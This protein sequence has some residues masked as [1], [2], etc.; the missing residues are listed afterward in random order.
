MHPSTTQA[1]DPAT[2]PRTAARQLVDTLVAHGV[3]RVFCVAGESFLAV[4][5]ALYDSPIDVVTCRHEASAGFAALA[6]AKLTG[7]PGVILV[8]RG[9]GASNATIAVHSAIQDAAPLLLVV[10]Q[11]ERNELGR[12][13]FQEVDYHLTYADLAKGVWTLHDAE[14]TSE[15][16]ARALRTAVQ[17][18]PGPTVLVL[19]E[20]VLN[21]TLPSGPQ[22]RSV[23]VEPAPPAPAAMAEI[24]RL[25][26]AAERPLVIAG[27]LLR[28]EES[29]RRLRDAAQRHLLPVAV[30]NKH[31]D[32]FDNTHPLYAGHLH[33]ATQA[34]QRAMLAQADLVIAVGTR[35]D[36]VTTQNHTLP[37]APVPTQPLV[38]VHPDPSALGRVTEPTI[39][40]ACDPVAF[41]TALADTTTVERHGEQR[42]AWAGLLHQAELA[43]A[44]WQPHESI[45]GLPFGAAV[46]ALGR[47]AAPDTIVTVDAGNFTS[48]VHRY[49]RFTDRGTLLGLGCGAMG[50]GVPSGLAAALR[51]PDRQVVTFVGDGGFLMT[52]TELATA[53]QRRARLAIIVAD[54]GSYGT[55]RQHQERAYPARVVATDLLNPD[56]AALALSFGARGL[57]VEEERDLVPALEEALGYDGPIVV[58]VRTSLSWISAYQHLAM[59]GETGT[60][61]HVLSAAGALVNG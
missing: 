2:G 38:H 15:M 24:A 51:H 31:Q 49:H 40:L 8:N 19:P 16:T 52:G 37:A 4:L 10:G 42:L 11:V 45:D 60:H 23:P 14:R 36:S 17:G 20:D 41:L 9:P 21:E 59:P 12:G 1:A 47:L 18:T 6:D 28:T 5:D 25:L 46:E 27:G 55:I 61:P 13:C 43:T 30:S 39:A 26:A 29:R 35:L 32:V 44:T 56:F 53:V 48:W 34:A 58:A 57:R 3:D 7:R 22:P 50:F 33:I 54:N